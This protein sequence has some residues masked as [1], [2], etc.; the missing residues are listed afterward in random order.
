MSFAFFALAAL[1]AGG[2]FA[3]VFHPLAR[4]GAKAARACMLVICVV[5]GAAL[6]LYFYLGRPD[7]ADM[8]AAPQLADGVVSQ[9]LGALKKLSVNP[10]DVDALVMLAAIRIAQG[11]EE[12]SITPL[13]TRA[14]KL[15]PEDRRV[16]MLEEMQREGD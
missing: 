1:L 4:Q 14:G 12:S 3:F 6:G 7:L 9:E 2:I 5:S 11:R 8:P 16:K 13:L 10:D 15:A